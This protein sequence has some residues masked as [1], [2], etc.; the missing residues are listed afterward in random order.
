[1]MKSVAPILLSFLAINALAQNVIITT[2]AENQQIP[3][4][5]P[6]VNMGSPPVD[7]YYPFNNNIPQSNINNISNTNAGNQNPFAN[8]NL[9][10]IF[11]YEGVISS[12]DDTD[13]DSNNNTSLFINA[14]LESIMPTGFAVGGGVS[15]IVQDSFK[16]AFYA[17]G[18]FYSGLPIL[19]TGSPSYSYIGGGMLLVNGSTFYPEIGIR[20]APSNSMRMD[21]FFKAYTSSNDDYDQ[22]AT[23]GIGLSF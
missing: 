16:T 5:G 11:T 22:R 7:A 4:S 20:L 21:L 6:V 18:R 23:L 13:N 2:D 10:N 1:M 9:A 15:F 19:N 8:G 12:P 14:G 17:G 3:T